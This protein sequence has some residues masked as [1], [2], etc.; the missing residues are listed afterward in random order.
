[1]M[2][3]ITVYADMSFHCL[4]SLQ[5][6]E[7]IS[8]DFILCMAFFSLLLQVNKVFNLLWVFVSVNLK[9]K[10]MNL[11]QLVFNSYKTKPHWR[12]YKDISCKY[13]APENTE[14]DDVIM[15]LIYLCPEMTTHHLVPCWIMNGMHLI[16]G[17]NLNHFFPGNFE[18]NKVK[19]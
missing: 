12:I 6:N 16:A 17:N 19:S 3:I 11:P 9:E 2:V 15:R 8:F 18:Y 10:N 4:I 13:L 14:I 7:N 5:N 1:M